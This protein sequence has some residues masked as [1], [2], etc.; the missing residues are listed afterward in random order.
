MIVRKA[1]L[2]RRAFSL[3]ELL[4]VIS[5]IALL[6]GLLLPAVQ[7]VREAANRV[8]CANNLK[9][10][11]LA[12]HHYHLVHDVLPSFSKDGDDAT[13]WCVLLLPFLEQGNLHRQWDMSKSYYN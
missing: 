2:W 8:A 11:G 7:R 1:G 10:I 4:V 3:I 12:M 5:I 13:T 9:Q 6:M